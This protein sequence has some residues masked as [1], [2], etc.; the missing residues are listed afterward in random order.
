MSKSALFT[1]FSTDEFIGHWDGKP[2][3]FAAGQSLYMPDYL[4]KHFAK[5]LANRELLRM[6]KERDTSPRHKMRPDGT[7]YVDNQNFNEM[8]DKAYTPDET[9]YLDA[10]EKKPDV[11]ALINVANK[12]RAATSAEQKPDTHA[13]APGP[14]DEDESDFKG[15]PVDTLPTS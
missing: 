9:E 6:G 13:P 10:G 4:A 15:K 11:D 5:H 3:K 14:I 2:K 7:L 12:N 1:N 8:F